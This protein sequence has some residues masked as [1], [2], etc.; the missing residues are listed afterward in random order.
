MPDKFLDFKSKDYFLERLG[1][2]DV[3]RSSF[4]AHYQ[5]TSEFVQPRRGRFHVEDR[6]KGDKRWGSI[7]NAR[8]SLA[9]RVAR[10]GMLAGVMSPARPWFALSLMDEAVME[11]QD[12]RVW[13]STGRKSSA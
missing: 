9:H 3:E 7:I 11:Q 1:S 6:N 13:L 12:V 2:L 5:E 4:I 8:A 10:S